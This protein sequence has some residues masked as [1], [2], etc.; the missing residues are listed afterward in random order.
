[1]IMIWRSRLR[2]HNTTAATREVESGL[3]VDA[4]SFKVNTVECALCAAQKGMLKAK[5]AELKAMQTERAAA[6]KGM[7]NPKQL[8]ARMYA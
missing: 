1:M 4:C 2:Q 5:K 7:L 3:G 8:E 6:T